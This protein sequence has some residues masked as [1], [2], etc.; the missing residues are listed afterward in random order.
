M[1][2]FVRYPGGGATLLA[3]VG[4]E[5]SRHGYGLQLA[6]LTGIIECAYCRLDLRQSYEAWLLTTVDHVIPTKQA[7]RLGIDPKW[8][9]N[10][11]NL[12]LACSGCNG[13]DNRYTINAEPR[14]SWSLEDFVMLR[15]SVFEER[16]VRIAPRRTNERAFYE[17]NW[18]MLQIL[19]P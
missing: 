4:S 6:R 3:P 15:D 10:P 7:T 1:N 17:Q 11:I 9:T 14:D 18:R 12:V 8:A 16:I 5:N 2:P 13:L 19:R